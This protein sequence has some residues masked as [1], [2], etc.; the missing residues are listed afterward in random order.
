MLISG[1]TGLIWRLLSGEFGRGPMA[2]LTLGIGALVVTLVYGL[3]KFTNPTF[4]PESHLFD[5]GDV[6]SLRNL[7]RGEKLDAPTREWAR[8][9]ADR[10]AV[11][12]PGRSAPAQGQSQPKT[13][14][15]RRP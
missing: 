9:L 4:H 5:W 13:P 1:L 14:A 10:I 15:V 6:D 12:L 3:L 7:A 8:S 2:A 11:V